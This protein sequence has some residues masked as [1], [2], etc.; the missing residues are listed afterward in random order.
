MGSLCLFLALQGH[1]LVPVRGLFACAVCGLSCWFQWFASSHGLWC[2]GGLCSLNLLAPATF[3]LRVGRC[4][5]SCLLWALRAWGF[6]S[7]SRLLRW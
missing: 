2:L 3:W 5:Y 7:L 4:A 1:V 6:C